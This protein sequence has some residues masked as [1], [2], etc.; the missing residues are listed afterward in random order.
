MPPFGENVRWRPSVT[1]AS[2]PTRRWLVTVILENRTAREDC[3]GVMNSHCTDYDAHTY[4]A[5]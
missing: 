4:L 1:D 2:K 5:N 3:A